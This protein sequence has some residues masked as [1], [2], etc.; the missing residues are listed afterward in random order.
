M[1][2]NFDWLK[3]LQKTSKKTEAVLWNATSEAEMEARSD[4]F[5]KFCI[6]YGSEDSRHNWV[7][8]PNCDHVLVCCDG[9][10]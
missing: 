7:T 8:H 3:R 5:V 4:N 9:L 1:E 2:P 6:K 10:H